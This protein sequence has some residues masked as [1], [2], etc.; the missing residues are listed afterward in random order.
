MMENLY[1][2]FYFL[3]GNIMAKTDCVDVSSY[4]AGANFKKMKA[5]GVKVAILKIGEYW[6][7][8]FHKDSQFETFYTNATA[9]GLK[10]GVYWFSHASSVSFAKQ[11]AAKTLEYLKKRK[12]NLP[13]YYDME[14]SAT[15]SVGKTAL[16]KVACAYCDAIK[17][18]GY[19]AG[20][21]ANPNWFNNYIDYN[22]LHKKYSIWLAQWGVDK[23]GKD[24]DVW[25][26]T[27]G[28]IS[29]FSGQIDLD[30]IINQKVIDGTTPKPTPTP[31]KTPSV[32]YRVQTVNKG[33]L[34][35]VKDLKDYAG[36]ENDPIKGVAIKV[37][38]GSIWYRVH[39]L[40]KGWLPKVTGYNIKDI[41]N[42]YAGNNHPIDAIQ[43][44]YQP[45]KGSKTQYC[46]KYQVSPVGSTS[47]CA[48]QKNNQK[49]K[50]QDGY[51]GK[52]G[53]KI[54]KLKI[55]IV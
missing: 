26:H 18:G 49:I 29:G 7:G 15:T 24:C 13:V 9:A 3:G 14:D 48:W 43:I 54:D 19:R 32:T 6:S 35:E 37:N 10:V 50:G 53:K 42:G 33:W 11:E 20:I 46:A 16:T 52:F 25:Q 23:P 39:E 21:Y 5:A 27:V 17:A 51:A 34:P 8:S 4:Q 38:Q 40:G 12:L 44:C 30:K 47:Y 31:T 36:I 1:K 41:K 2:G 28:T 55:S 45:P 22:T